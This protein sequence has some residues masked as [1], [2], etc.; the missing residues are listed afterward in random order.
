MLYLQHILSKWAWKF[1]SRSNSIP[2][3]SV[4]SLSSS[5][6][7]SLLI[8]YEYSLRSWRVLHDGVIERHFEILSSNPRPTT[9]INNEMKSYCKSKQTLTEYISKNNFKSSAKI[10]NFQL[11]I[12]LLRSLINNENN[13]GTRC[14]TRGTPNDTS[15]SYFT[16]TT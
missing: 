11:T 6:N 5:N 4:I 3:K 1:Y 2:W 10:R 15:I 7:T 12:D 14:P 8:A 13:N 9:I 16:P